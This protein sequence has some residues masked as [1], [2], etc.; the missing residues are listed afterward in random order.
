V[1]VSPRGV[2]DPHCDRHMSAP[3][4]LY[5][6]GL[7][8]PRLPLHN[9]E[10]PRGTLKRRTLRRTARA[11]TQRRAW[12]AVNQYNRCSQGLTTGG[13][14]L[15]LFFHVAPPCLCVESAAD[16]YATPCCMAHQRARDS[17]KALARRRKPGPHSCSRGVRDSLCRAGPS[18]LRGGCGSQRVWG[19][20]CATC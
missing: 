7:E 4:I 11:T 5:A 17:S 14:C 16:L 3:D 20:A 10:R 15:C 18:L 9:S 1:G 19:T 12:L 2:R 13:G 6:T 8:T